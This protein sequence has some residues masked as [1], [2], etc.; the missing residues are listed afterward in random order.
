MLLVRAGSSWDY[1]LRSVS[2][3]VTTRL[4][5]PSDPDEF[6]MVVPMGEDNELIAANTAE[7]I[8]QAAD[9]PARGH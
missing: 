2:E 3:T 7:Q 6:L 5:K 1:W 9:L 4:C 8:A